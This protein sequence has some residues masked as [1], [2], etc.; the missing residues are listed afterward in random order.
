MDHFWYIEC[1]SS[2]VRQQQQLPS[3]PPPPP[4]AAPKYEYYFEVSG[5][6]LISVKTRV[7]LVFATA[8]KNNVDPCLR[9]QTNVD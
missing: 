4:K 2:K 3:T 7:V 1:A 8:R 9:S 6:K 5:E